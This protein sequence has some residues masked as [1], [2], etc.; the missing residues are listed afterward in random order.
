MAEDVIIASEADMQSSL[1]RLAQMQRMVF[2]TGL[3]GVGKSLYIR[4][5]ALA[6]HAAGRA[7]HLL[8]WDVARPA[9]ELPGIIARYPERDGVTHAV[10]RKAVG[11]WAREAV[12]QWN[13][14]HRGPGHMLITEAPLIGN[15]LLELAQQQS[16]EAEPLLAG[17]DALFVTPVPSVA[18]RAVIEAARGRTFA[19]PKHSR[20]A[21]DAPPNVLQMLYQEVHALAVELG[22]ATPVVTGPAP[23]DPQAYAAVYGRLLRHRHAL[24]LWIDVQLQPPQSVYDLDISAADVLPAPYDAEAI[25]ARLEREHTT[26]EI[27]HEVATWFQTV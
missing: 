27:E 23:F 16:D 15:R 21:S 25:L 14:D 24:S 17:R 1:A 9:F 6:A 8:Q 11:Q 10:I 5:L 12:V 2:V 3:P 26:A 20:E 19:N 4:E 7:V 18:V 13:R 22:A